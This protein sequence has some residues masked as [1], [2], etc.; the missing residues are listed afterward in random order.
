M[1]QRDFSKDF[2]SKSSQSP[3]RNFS[4]VTS[5]LDL[6]MYN[7]YTAVFWEILQLMGCTMRKWSMGLDCKSPWKN[8]KVGISVWKLR[9]WRSAPKGRWLMRWVWVYVYIFKY[10]Y[11]YVMREREAQ[12]FLKVR[13]VYGDGQFWGEW[14]EADD[15]Q[16]VL[17]TCA[18]MYIYVNV[19]I[20]MCECVYENVYMYI[21]VEMRAR[22]R[23]F[24]KPIRV[25]K[26]EILESVPGGRW[27]TGCALHMYMLVYIYVY[28]YMYICIHIYIYTHNYMCECLCI[29]IYVYIFMYIHMN[30]RVNSWLGRC[31]IHIY[32]APSRNRW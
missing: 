6:T 32:T 11:V 22:D 19:Y 2:D 29:C 16:G 14:W 10:V 30:A 21:Y 17:Y 23:I 5:L 18:C 12:N 26:V 20:C 7:G 25:W 31:V 28:Q 27:L 4:R 3:L 9:I 24:W 8:L 13:W 1:T 15:W